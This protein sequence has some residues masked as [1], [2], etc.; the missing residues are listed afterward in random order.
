MGA[1]NIGNGRFKTARFLE[2]GQIETHQRNHN[3]HHNGCGT[4]RLRDNRWGAEE[5]DAR[6]D[7]G[8]GN[9]RR[10]EVLFP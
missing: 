9:E 3:Q 6:A 5:I 1:T 4:L 8:N 10:C 2:R 7:D